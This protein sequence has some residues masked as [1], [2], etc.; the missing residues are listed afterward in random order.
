MAQ[1]IRIE[2]S[3]DEK[4]KISYDGFVGNA[5]FAKAE[6]VRLAFANLGLTVDTKQIIETKT[7][8]EVRRLENS[9]GVGA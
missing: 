4:F 2:V 6:Q 9:Q 1:K 8:Q 7:E 5:C 3:P